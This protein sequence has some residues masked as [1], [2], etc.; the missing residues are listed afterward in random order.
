MSS[1]IELYQQAYD[2]DYRKGDWE[3]AKELYETIVQ[4]FPHSEEAEYCRVHLDRLEKLNS[5]PNNQELQPVRSKKAP[6]ALSILSLVLVLPLIVATV[7]GFFYIWQQN[8]ANMYYELLAEGQVNER[9]GLYEPAVLKYQAAQAIVPMNALSYRM[10]AELYLA[11][12]KMPLAEVQ[13]KGWQLTY[14]SDP[15]LAGFSVRMKIKRE[16]SAGQK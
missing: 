7:A 9:L 6:V 16:E 11:K 1:A 10:L 14:P 5:D 4:K 2:A 13:F 8:Q 3:Y 15:D 12:D